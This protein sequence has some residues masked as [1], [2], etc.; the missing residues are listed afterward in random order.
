MSKIYVDVIA[1]FS[2]E[3]V[4][5][6]REIIWEDGR[7]YEIDK[8]VDARLAASLKAGGVGIRYTCKIQG[9]D[10]YIFYETNN[11]WFVEGK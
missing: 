2:K 8:V 5:R 11:K 9:R 7:K 3:G 4:L 1:S 6:P 10:K